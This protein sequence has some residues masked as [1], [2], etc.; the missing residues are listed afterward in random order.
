MRIGYAR[1]STIEQDTK[2][3]TDALKKVK[4]DRIITEKASGAKIDRPELMRVL[5]IARKG[6]VLIVWKLD[7][8]D[9]SASSSR[10]FSFSM[11]KAYSCAHSPKT[12]TRR[13][14]VASLSSMS[15]L[16]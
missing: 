13:L 15:L 12:S 16:R 9:Q 8:L 4:C 3:Q 6:D 10:P 5:D 7:R 11:T 1:V 14:P 2:L